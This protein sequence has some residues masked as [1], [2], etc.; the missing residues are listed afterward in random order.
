ML[1]QKNSGVNWVR[2]IPQYMKALNNE[3]R[4]ELAWKSPLEIYFGR[5][6][7]ELLKCGLEGAQGQPEI[8]KDISAKKKDYDNAQNKV[9]NLRKKAYERGCKIAEKSRKKYFDKNKC[10]MYSL[11]QMILVRYGKK[12][13][14]R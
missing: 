5:K 14:D 12:G 9:I 10:P 6:S 8:R 2:N 4:E 1:S 11:N 13:K 7:N 3:K